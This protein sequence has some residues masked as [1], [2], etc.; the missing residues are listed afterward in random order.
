MIINWCHSEFGIGIIGFFRRPCCEDILISYTGACLCLHSWGTRGATKKPEGLTESPQLAASL[1][2]LKLVH[3][4]FFIYLEDIWSHDIIIFWEGDMASPGHH[5]NTPWCGTVMTRDDGGWSQQWAARNHNMQHID[6]AHPPARPRSAH[7]QC[8]SIAYRPTD[9][10]SLSDTLHHDYVT[11]GHSLSDTHSCAAVL[12]D[13]VMT[14]QWRRITCM[15]IITGEFR[16][17]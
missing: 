14:S 5:L 7:H 10:H 16:L 2:A 12:A 9:R 4:A 15:I 1:V 17:L 11:R 13:D 6:G 3:F 8:C